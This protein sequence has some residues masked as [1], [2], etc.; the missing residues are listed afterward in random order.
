VK[1]GQKGESMKKNLTKESLIKE[2]RLFCDKESDYQNK[3]LYGVTDGKA[4]GTHIE[5]KFQK[6]LKE[7]Y[8]YTEGSAARGI[9]FPD[10]YINT[11]M[12]VT[13]I[14]Q[15]QSSCPFRDARQKIY[16]LGYNLLLFVYEKK[17]DQKTQT[18]NLNFK[19]C[20]F[21]A[22]ERTGDYQTT[23]SILQMIDNGANTDDIIAYLMDRNIPAD[24][25]TLNKISDEILQNPPRQG[26]LTI[27]N[28]LQWRLQYQRI[29]T[30]T[31]IPDGIVK[32]VH[33]L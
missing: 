33:K 23:K 21:I 13:S 7:Q 5:H 11:D 1:F 31:D 6:V 2:A 20:S 27:S 15:P 30:L 28:A 18:A 16:G 26:Y 25:I 24:E 14:V 12:K 29:V 4:V 10:E 17:D 9:D 32:I 8:I 3:D 19:S 22:K